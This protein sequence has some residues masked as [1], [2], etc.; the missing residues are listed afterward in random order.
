MAAVLASV[1]ASKNSC[2][3][4]T[5]DQEVSVKTLAEELKT[6]ADAAQVCGS[7]TRPVEGHTYLMFQ[8]SSFTSVHVTVDLKGLEVV[9]MMRRLARGSTLL[10]FPS[11]P[12]VSLL[13]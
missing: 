9:M 3:L 2:A 8:V 13:S 1:A 6:L 10:L 7:E 12:P 4:V 11:S 5:A